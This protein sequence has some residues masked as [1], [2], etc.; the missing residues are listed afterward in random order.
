MQISDLEIFRE[1]EP[2]LLVALNALVPRTATA[3]TVLFRPGDLPVGYLVVLSGRIAVY[4]SGK[5]GREMLLYEVLDGET[6]IQTTLCLLGDK[7]YT[8]EA[9][10]MT[11]TSYVVIPKTAFGEMMDSSPPFR[12]V[13]FRAF[14]NRLQD[15]VAVLEKV[16]FVRLDTRLASEILRRAGTDGAASATHQE[17]ATAVGTVREVVSRR[18]EMLQRSGFVRLDRGLITITD[19]AGLIRTSKD[20]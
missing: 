7:S 13:I 17:L 1:L 15:V 14:G 11:E 20:E 19:R 12:S 8:G 5:S 4:L 18:L 10:A 9:V 3:G 2:R 16:A 6:C